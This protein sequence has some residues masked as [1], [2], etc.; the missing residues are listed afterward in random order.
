MILDKKRLHDI[1]IKS[2]IGSSLREESTLH[3]LS[4]YIGKMK[5]SM[6]RA[7]IRALTNK[8]DTVLDPFCGSGTVA[9]ESWLSGRH[10]V[11]VD[12]NP[13]ALYLTKGKLFPYTSFDEACTDLDLMTPKANGKIESVDLREVPK[14]VRAFFHPQTLREAI[15]WATLLK[16]NHRYFLLACLLGIL[17]HQRPGFLSYPSSHTVPYLREKNFPRG[18]FPHLYDYRS[19]RDRLERKARLALRRVRNLDWSLE[20]TCLIGDAGSFAP[21]HKVHAIIT[22]PPYMRQLDYGRDNRLRLWFLGFPNW[23]RID[24]SVS[25]SEKTF[26]NLFR[27]CL[28]VWHEALT[29]NGICGLVLGDSYSKSYGLRLPEL[30]TDL[31]INDTGAYRLLYKKTDCIPSERRV[32]RGYSGS[33][34]ETILILQK[35]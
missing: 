19:V 12:L 5:S 30:V 16:S 29:P 3:Q 21:K 23:K 22:S 6:A 25:P 24:L 1:K 14:W 7:L 4:P 10:T 26:V 18:K 9:L 34:T 17:H 35:R 11:A 20:R 28:E 8:G 15:A 33:K 27:S 32:R 13:Y 2:W 31:A